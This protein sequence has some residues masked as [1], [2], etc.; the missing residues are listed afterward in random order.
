MV[1]SLL[2]SFL[3]VL[4]GVF[5]LK[6]C[7]I[8]VSHSL[9]AV[10]A[11]IVVILPISVIQYFTDSIQ[12][13]GLLPVLNILL[14]S[15]LIYGLIEETLKGLTI[16]LLPSKLGISADYSITQN[17][18]LAFFFGLTI[19]CF[20]SEVYFL[21]HLMQAN[22]WGATL[23]YRPILLRMIT[24]DLL[25]GFCAAITGI[26]MYKWNKD[27]KHLLFILTPIFIHTFYDFFAGF[28]NNLKIFSIVVI[29]YSALKCYTLLSTKVDDTRI[30][31]NN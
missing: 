1:L 4:L 28:Q 11:A 25:H 31:K 20:E 2:L 9:I 7:K 22:S 21:S 24:T 8:K 15:F 16:A 5:I 3:P 30:D 29:L 6:A 26:F 18:G 17:A 19:G 23:L 12:I 10:L 13:P 14:K 27:E